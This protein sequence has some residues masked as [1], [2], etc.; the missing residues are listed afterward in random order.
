MRAPAFTDRVLWKRR[1]PV[2]SED[3]WNPGKLVHYGRAELKQ[4]DHRPVIAI[5]ECEIAEL[6]VEKRKV[7]I[8]DV[9]KDMGPPDSTIVINVSLV[10]VFFV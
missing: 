7:V 3:P 8:D 5:L 9:I 10:C 2:I 6:D 4:S 1:R